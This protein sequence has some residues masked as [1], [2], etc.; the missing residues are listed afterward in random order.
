MLFG[1]LYKGQN[2]YKEITSDS[3]PRFMN[4][5]VVLALFRVAV[6]QVSLFSGA[7]SQ[8]AFVRTPLFGD[9]LD[10]IQQ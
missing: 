8:V 6:F 9:I 5:F 1:L 7:F 2:D 3:K 4:I 10:V